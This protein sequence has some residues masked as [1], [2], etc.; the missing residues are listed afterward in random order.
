MHLSDKKKAYK[1]EDLTK[2]VVPC[3]ILVS[4]KV[5]CIYELTGTTC[6]GLWHIVYVNGQYCAILCM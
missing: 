4:M 3:V 2:Y 6:V 1:F 5:Y